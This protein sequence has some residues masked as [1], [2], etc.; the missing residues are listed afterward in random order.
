MSEKIPLSEVIGLIKE[1]LDVKALED[2]KKRQAAVWEGK[3]PDYLPLIFGAANPERDQYPKYDMK[4]QFFDPEKMLYEQLWG[5][6]SVLRA[7]SDAV[8][9]IRVN[10]G[11]GFLCSVFGLNQQIFPD[12]MPW[13][14]EHLSKDAILKLKPG[15]LEPI[16]EK[17]LMP[18]FKRYITLYQE[19]L[20]GLPVHIYLPDTQGAFDV[21]HLIYRDDIFTDL[22]DDAPFI[23]HL[24]S[25]TEYVYRNASRLMKE[26]I[27]EPMDSG[28]H[29]GTLYMSGCGVRSCEDSTTLLSPGLVREQVMPYL[30]KSVAPFGGWV[31]FCGDGQGLLEPLLSA[32]EVKGVNFGN[33]ERF[34]WPVTM[35]RIAAAGKVY[36][37]GI[38][39]G[40]KEQLSDYFTRILALLPKKGNLIMGAPLREG[41]DRADAMTL[42]HRLQ[43]KRFA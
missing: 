41:E 2:G 43:D 17:G 9:S 7:R 19:K 12:K 5:P 16:A 26:W 25:L 4:E 24:L 18:E 13:L 37:G 39:R 33:P 23:S 30:R 1:E 32:P 28:Y 31:H 6:L 27:G 8:P 3:E 40:E 20:K 35:A 38:P 15:D 10:F 29:G 11:T 14:Q 34:D 22:Y 21:A 42:W 36:F